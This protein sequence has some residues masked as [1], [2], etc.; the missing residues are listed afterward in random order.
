MC[1]IN[2]SRYGKNGSKSSAVVIT[3][4][5]QFNLN[6][7]ILSKIQFIAILAMTAFV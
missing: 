7:I 6:H 5:S 1:K 4:Q 2:K 3:S